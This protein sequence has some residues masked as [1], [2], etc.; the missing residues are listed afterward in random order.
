MNYFGFGVKE[1]FER[2]TR[3]LVVG[4]A[5]RVERLE[6][7]AK[8]LVGKAGKL[9]A[10]R[11]DITKKEEVINA[12]KWITCT[13]GPISILINN[14]G[15]SRHTTLID[16]D[17]SIWSMVLDTN[18]MG[19]CLAT[20]EAIASMKANSI[21][22]HIVHVN[23]IAGHTV[24]SNNMYSPSKFAVTSITEVMRK[25]LLN[26]ES[27]IKVSSISPGMT[28]TEMLKLQGDEIIIPDDM[29]ALN[30]EDVANSI[31]HILGTPPHVQIHELIIKPVGEAF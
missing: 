4:L 5:R 19:L 29:P 22:G 20:R 8:A 7:S 12:F 30:P 23:S 3:I 10:Y 13:V 1:I 18:V 6:E 21:D 31:I 27:K 15:V 14:A 28:D 26:A 24:Y 17:D 25:E 11:C 9:H 2:I 16:G